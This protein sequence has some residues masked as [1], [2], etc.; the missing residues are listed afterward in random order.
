V[1]RRESEGRRSSAAWMWGAVSPASMVQRATALRARS[2]ME[3]GC[4]GARIVCSPC[5]VEEDAA[6]TRELVPT[7]ASWWHAT[8][9]R[10]VSRGCGL[11][12]VVLWAPCHFTSG[13]LE[14]RVRRGMWWQRRGDGDTHSRRRF[15]RPPFFILFL[16]IT[17]YPILTSRCRSPSAATSLNTPAGTTFRRP[18]STYC[19]SSCRRIARS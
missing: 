2:V 17:H 5:R 10:L 13:V 19:G 6:E 1:T 7:G 16:S 9:G 18:Q 15:L 3:R 8:E 11:D 4:R 12:R 14:K